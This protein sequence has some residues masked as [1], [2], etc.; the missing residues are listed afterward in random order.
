MSFLG[1]LP[2][3]P[4]AIAN[5]IIREV[6]LLVKDGRPGWTAR[7]KEVLRKRGIKNGYNVYPDPEKKDGAWLLDLIWMHRDTGA[8]HLAVESELGKERE[9]LDDFQ[10]LLSVKAPL[11]VMIYY[12]FDKPF[13]TEFE[14]Y[15]EAFDQHV[16]GENY[17]LI[18]FAPGRNAPD[19]RAYLFTVKAD[20]TVGRHRVIIG[21]KEPRVA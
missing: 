10:K 4:I 14:R 20:G 8:I 3:E 1:K 6:R 18:E 5:E 21:A 19:D 13:L 2:D 7:L 16:P 11:K 12:L 15:I 9:V 17:L